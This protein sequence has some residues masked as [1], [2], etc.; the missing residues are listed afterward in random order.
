VGDSGACLFLISRRRAL[1]AV[2]ETR[3]G[4]GQTWWTFFLCF[5]LSSRR[6]RVRTRMRLPARR[7]PLL[8]FFVLVSVFSLA[9]SRFCVP[10]MR[11]GT[12]LG[13][14]HPASGVWRGGAGPGTG[15]GAD[16]DVL[17]WRREL[18]VQRETLRARRSSVF[19]PSPRSSLEAFPVRDG[20]KGAGWAQCLGW[21]GGVL[22]CCFAFPCLA[23]PIPSSSHGD[24]D[25]AG[26]ARRGLR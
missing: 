20:K 5:F 17:L 16:P 26:Q 19:V 13:M 24:L 12:S 3:R 22:R 10:R 7:P 2:L 21:V 8:S 4:P 25:K 6:V 15:T 23:T 14:T 18:V 9:L 1:R 11:M